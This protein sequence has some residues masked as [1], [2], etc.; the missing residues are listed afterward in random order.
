MKT[1]EDIEKNKVLKEDIISLV[2]V[3]D[4]EVL[5]KAS[6]VVTGATGLI[7]SQ[8]IKTL[9]YINYYKGYDIRVIAITRNQE[10]AKELLGEDDNLEIVEHN[11]LCPIHLENKMDY[12]IHC[13][14][15]TKSRTFICKP[16]ETIDVAVNGTKNMLE[17]ATQKNI[18]KFIYISSM[19]IYGDNVEVATEETYG[20]IDILEARNSY[21]QAK[22]MSETLSMAYYYERRV[23]VCIARLCQTFGVGVDIEE[24][25]MFGQFARAAINRENI[26]LHTKGE[27]VRSYC[28]LMDTISGIFCLMIKG[29]QGEAYNVSNED[30]TMSVRDIAYQVAY[31][32]NIDVV[33]NLKDAKSMGYLPTIKM[34]MESKKLRNLGWKPQ[35]N[36]ELAFARMI[37]SM[38][39]TKDGV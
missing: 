2:N 30:M 17:L 11:I 18:K 32:N 6:I 37:E 29:K 8:I 9:I 35:V 1:L 38:K 19:E 24:E 20:K 14:S 7:G 31:N 22:R 5:K 36:M 39:I 26:T 15:I 16:I 25:R 27:T 23:P 13:A 34:R 33:F 21:P 12:I 10:R 28:Y 3:L 4:L